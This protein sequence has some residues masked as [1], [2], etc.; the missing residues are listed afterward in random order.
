MIIQWK[1]IRRGSWRVEDHTQ[2][3]CYTVRTYYR[4]VQDINVLCPWLIGRWNVDHVTQLLI[5]LQEVIFTSF[6]GMSFKPTFRSL[7]SRAIV[8]ESPR[9]SEG[10]VLNGSRTMYLLFK[11][12]EWILEVLFAASIEGW[13]LCGRSS[14]SQ[15]RCSCAL[16]SSCTVQC[17]SAS[18]WCL[19]DGSDIDP[20]S[21]RRWC[22]EQ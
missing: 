4:M 11:S 10:F 14:I 6:R 19:E 13:S 12:R 16:I 21:I 8:L 22:V 3:R 17:W 18:K 5:L 1:P 9:F 15:K 2:T 20:E 7:I